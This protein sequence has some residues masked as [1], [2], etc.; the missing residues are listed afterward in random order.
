MAEYALILA[1]VAVVVIVAA[2][3]IGLAVQRIYGVAAAALGVKRN[4]AGPQHTIEITDPALCIA[5]ESQ[6]KTGLWI[7]GL[8]DMDVA[9]LT[10]STEV[11]VGTGMAG[12]L[13]PVEPNGDGGFKFH[14]LLAYSVDLSV[15]PKTI[16]IQAK[17]GTIA[18]APVKT[19]V[20]P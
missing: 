8:T 15:C 6:N 13:S 19:K 9:D 20:I 17:D 18:L 4:S 14:P 1:L 11:A 2:F 3:A 10:G 7:V 16:V 12:D 5:S